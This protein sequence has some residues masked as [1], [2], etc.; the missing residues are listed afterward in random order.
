MTDL[1]Q[2]LV[3]GV[4]AGAVV[5]L[6]AAGFTLTFAVSRQVN[7]AHGNIFALTTVAV[8]SLTRALGVTAATPLAGRLAVLLLL[9][10]AGA[11]VGG[12]LGGVVERLAFR[13]FDGRREPLGPL[14]ASLALSFLMLGIA[15]RWHAIT[16]V[17][18]PAHQGV[19]LPMLAMPDLVPPVELGCCAISVTLKD[20]LVLAIGGT[21]ALGGTLALAR[22]RAG[23]MLRGIAEDAELVALCGGNPRYGR[24]L[25]FVAAGALT[26]VAAAIFAA[27]YGGTSANHGLRGG[28]TAMTAAFLG[29]I[30]NP[31]GAL[32]GGVAIGVLG[33][34]GDF[35][36]SAFWTPVLT[37]LLLVGLLAWR[38]AGLLGSSIPPVAE[39][40]VGDGRR[41]TGQPD[42]RAHRLVWL[43]LALALV[44]PLLGSL[45]GGVRLYDATIVLLLVALALGLEIV[46]G[47]AGLLDLGYAAFFAIGG[48][49]M[50]ML[51]A[52]SSRLAPMLPA[53][54]HEPWLALPLAALAA[55][56]CGI[57]FGLPSIRARGEYL[58]VVTL[59]LGEIVP[60]LVIRFPD[61]TS[62]A[63]GISGIV[64]PRV[65]LT[66]DGSALGTYGLALLL[67]AGVWLLAS[68]LA[69]ARLGR[70]WAAVRDDELAAQSVGVD[71]TGVKLQAF[72]LG[73]GVAGLA[74]ALFAGL[75]GHIVPEQ[76]D[77][78]LSLMVLSAVAI[79]GRWG[80]AG[81]MAGALLVALYDRLLVDLVSAGLR[82]IGGLLTWPLPRATDLRGDNFLVFGL[83]L[84]LATLAPARRLPLAP[85][86]APRAAQ[87][88]HRTPAPSA[89]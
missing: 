6:S 36:L 33:S 45:L 11:V 46:V 27:Y 2:I 39:Q 55:A 70:A 77:L 9:V 89:E 37:L 13:P 5:A 81:V 60:A 79:G 10:A 29:G 44:Y 42:A 71:A 72:A 85:R 20:L 82:S 43:L 12:L 28:L 17:P 24:L 25:G 49:T 23:R 84:Y 40:P 52:G 18:V 51:T 22:S 21:V 74:G 41:S 88:D 64:S 80:L 65:P 78:T 50:A 19:N 69:G 58:A 8:A 16:T 26:G 30:G 59:A 53:I 73:A 35:F 57:V 76:F 86:R 62:G 87:R 14:I 47:F 31:A 1:L 63:R 7:L 61:W 56:G 34:L 67:A 32:L 83:L 75:V 38:P 68:R 15:V 54:L 66:P 48:Y 4:T 3:F